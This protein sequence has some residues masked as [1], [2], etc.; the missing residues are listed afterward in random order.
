MIQRYVIEVKEGWSG[1]WFKP[2]PDDNG[3]LCEFTDVESAIAAAVEA[4]RAKFRWLDAAEVTEPGWYAMR[5]SVGW[6]NNI[7]E[8]TATDLSESLLIHLRGN[9]RFLKLPDDKGTT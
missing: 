2:V 8:I 1:P 7:V 5:R 3:Y 9:P 4:E 6:S